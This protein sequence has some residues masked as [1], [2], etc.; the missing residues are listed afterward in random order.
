MAKTR[1]IVLDVE[2]TGV[3]GMKG[4]NVFHHPGFF[5]M[6]DSA[7]VIQVAWKVLQIENGKLVELETRSFD[8]LPTG[9]FWMNPAA[10]SIH[11]I[12][13]DHI[14]SHGC[15]MQEALSEL[16]HDLQDTSYLVGHN[17]I[18]DY[19]VLFSEILRLWPQFPLLAHSFSQLRLLC[20]MLSGTHFCNLW[21]RNGDCKWPKLTELFQKL[22][23][24]S[25]LPDGLH[26]AS[27][28]VNTTTQ[29]L[30]EMYRRKI[31]AF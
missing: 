29:C 1:L 31:V 6:Y 25:D 27:V 8:I 21:R 18:F 17:V 30:F 15:P 20:T 11:G 19:N 9:M 4:F 3:P 23:P 10:E 14:I 7:R 2:T 28:D 26:D 12:S 5:Q 16:Q 22:F 24:G 13:T